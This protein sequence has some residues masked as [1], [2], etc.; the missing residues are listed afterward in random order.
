MP[1]ALR[2]TRRSPVIHTTSTTRPDTTGWP[3]RPARALAR[4]RCRRN[5]PA[6]ACLAVAGASDSQRTCPPRRSTRRTSRPS[7][8]I[9]GRLPGVARPAMHSWRLRGMPSSMHGARSVPSR[10]SPVST[11][12]SVTHSS[13]KASSRR[14]GVVGAVLPGGQTI[15]I[16][17]SLSDDAIRA[18]YAPNLRREID[19][20]R[21]AGLRTEEDL[22]WTALDVFARLYAETMDQEQGIGLLLLHRG[23]LSQAPRRARRPSA[24]ACHPAGRRGCGGGPVHRARRPR[25]DAPGRNQRHAAPPL[26]VQGARGRRAIVGPR[27]REPRPAPG[28]WA[29]RPGGLP[30]L[31]QDPL[32]RA[33]PPVLTPAAGSWTRR[34]GRWPRPPRRRLAT[35]S[36]PH[37][38]PSDPGKS[39]A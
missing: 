31:V 9:P 36:S 12:S 16:D 26:A 25:A 30:V 24:P 3:R 8:G 27:P 13:W 11:P 35:G 39:S 6:R 29:G 20:A 22:D 4:T 19:A 21:R 14:P 15:S 34:T 37:T 32:L 10:R 5:S 38:A 18:E 17:C 2:G 33:P 1:M 23:R 7:M 28:R